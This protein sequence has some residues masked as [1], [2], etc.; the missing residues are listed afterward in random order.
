MLNMNATTYLSSPSSA[1]GR[2][3]FHRFFCMS[4][5]VSTRLHSSSSPQHRYVL[6]VACAFI[7]YRRT[8]FA[9]FGRWTHY[10]RG[11][12]GHENPVNVSLGV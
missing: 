4:Q 7:F 11:L 5:A 6:A 2:V 8:I 9:L 1:V 3:T 12:I 10:Q